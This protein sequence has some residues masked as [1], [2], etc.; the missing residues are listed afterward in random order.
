MK[1]KGF[2]VLRKYKLAYVLEE[3]KKSALGEAPI[4][5]FFLASYPLQYHD[6][7]TSGENPTSPTF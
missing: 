7:E 6:P 2:F 5:V 3:I 1:M 4:K